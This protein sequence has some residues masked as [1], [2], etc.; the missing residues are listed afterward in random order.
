MSAIYEFSNNIL[1]YLFYLA[2]MIIS[3]FSKKNEMM[4]KHRK[5]RFLKVFVI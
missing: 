3:Y 5:K 2:S 4:E 1:F